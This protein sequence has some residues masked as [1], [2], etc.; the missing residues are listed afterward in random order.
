MTVTMC[1]SSSDDVARHRPY[2]FANRRAE[3]RGK[4]APRLRSVLGITRYVRA[5]PGRRVQTANLRGS[6]AGTPFALPRV[7]AGSFQ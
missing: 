3:E 4:D 1:L 7:T 6:R 5:I 2:S